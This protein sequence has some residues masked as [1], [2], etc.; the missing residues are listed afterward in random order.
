MVWQM[1]TP[2]PCVPFQSGSRLPRGDTLQHGKQSQTLNVEALNQ[3]PYVCGVN[4]VSYL[5][6]RLY[7]DS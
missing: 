4:L 6:I 7:R 3:V 1:C 5:G 2:P